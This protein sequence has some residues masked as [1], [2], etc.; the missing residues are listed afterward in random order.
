[1]DDDAGAESPSGQEESQDVS[2]WQVFTVWETRGEW[3]VFCHGETVPSRPGKGAQTITLRSADESRYMLDA[4]RSAD[5]SEQARFLLMDTAERAEHVSGY[6]L[7]VNGPSLEEA[8]ATAKILASEIES[9][10]DKLI[11]DTGLDPR[12]ADSWIRGWRT[13]KGLTNEQVR[14]RLK[15]NLETRLAR[16]AA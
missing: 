14:D 16:R 13:E 7:Q 15:F 5:F 6:A 2:P 9:Y 3:R 11:T 1:V 12:N 4:L 10:R 8:R